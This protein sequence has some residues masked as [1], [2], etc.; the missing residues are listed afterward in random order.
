[1]I[2]RA[3]AICLPLVLVLTACGSGDDTPVTEQTDPATVASASATPKPAEPTLANPAPADATP[4]SA[5]EG[6][7]APAVQVDSDVVRT[8]VC[9]AQ[10]RVEVAI[11]AMGRGDDTTLASVLVDNADAAAT[12]LSAA[13]AKSTEIQVR[14]DGPLETALGALGMLDLPEGEPVRQ[15]DAGAYETVTTELQ[16]LVDLLSES[17]CANRDGNES[18]FCEAVEQVAVIA[19]GE[20]ATPEEF[21][22]TFDELLESAR[23]AAAA[24]PDRRRALL[25]EWVTQGTQTLG[26]L[27]ER[28]NFD[29]AAV[30]PAAAE[31]EQVYP[32]FVR[33]SNDLPALCDR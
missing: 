3:V 24:A 1:M 32:E 16:P 19:E 25:L 7:P 31:V 6:S 4:S 23:A 10:L 22:T 17:Y 13:I 8:D 18:S 5:P 9:T 14:P 11:T 21:R 20:P 26:A 27:G 29:I 2:R 30:E 12:D 28:A 15:A 33:V